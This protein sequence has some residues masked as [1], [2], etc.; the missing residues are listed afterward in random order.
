MPRLL[1]AERH[2]RGTDRRVLL[3]RSEHIGGAWL[4]P[5]LGD[6]LDDPTPMVRIGVDAL[7]DRVDSLRGRELAMIA[8]DAIARR[9]PS[10]PAF[11]PSFE[12]SRA[13]RYTDG[14]AREARQWLRDL[15]PAP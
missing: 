8:I 6:V 14:Q 7:P 13:V 3:K 12:I 4:L 15:P 10:V 2:S 9:D 5:A 1:H 11:R